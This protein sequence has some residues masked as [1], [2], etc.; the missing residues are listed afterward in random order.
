MELNGNIYWSH[1]NKPLIKHISGVINNAKKLAE[2]TS[3][4][5]WAE[6]TAIYH[7]LGKINPNFQE[8]LKPIPNPQGY[9]NHAYMS[10]YSFFVAFGCVSSNKGL[11]A[12]WLGVEKISKNDLIS[13]T[14]IIAKHHGNLPNY[15]PIDIDGTGSHILSKDENE[16]LHKFLNEKLDLP[17]DE[18][19]K[20]FFSEIE[21]FES[22]L[23]D[24]K[25]QKGYI[26]KFIFNAVS[27]QK[28]L[29]FY[30]DTQY[31]F[32]CLIQGDKTDAAKF[33]VLVDS[34]SLIEENILDVGR[35]CQSYQ[36]QLNFYLSKLNQDSE[37]NRLRTEIRHEA[38]DKIQYGLKEGKRVFELT[39]PTGSGKTLMLL[40]L[41]SEVMKETKKDLRIIYAL[42]FL[43]ITEQVETEVLKIFSKNQNFIQRI[44]SKSQ[45]AEFERLQKKLDEDPDED[46]MRKMNLM[47]FME[48]T[49]AHPFI[50][51]TFVRFF[52]TLLS[53]RNS[54]LLKLPNF[55]N[56]VFL[57]DEI[58]ALPPRLYGFFVAYLTK[59]CEKFDS[60]A[61]I[62]T[63]T[64]PNFDLPTHRLP[65]E[66]NGWFDNSKYAVDFFSD[67]GKP[68]PLLSLDYFKNDLFN[69]YQI[70]FNKD[71]IDNEELKKQIIDENESVLVILNTID[72]TKDLYKALV[73]NGF[74]KNEVF[75]LNT[76]FTPKH[77][78]LKIYLAKRRLKENKKIILIS[79]QL[80]EAGVDI[81]FPILY[82][83]FATIPSIIQSAGRCN[84][85]GKLKKMGKVELFRLGKNGRPR[86]EVIYRGLDEAI[87]KLTKEE[88]REEEYEEKTLL[89]IQKG[90][91][92][93][94]K[95]ELK[96]AE[97]KQSKYNQY[98]H[99]LKDIQ[100]CQFDK[101][102]KFQL[103][104][105]Q[106]Y[107]IP[108]QYF[109]PKN[110]DDS[111]FENLLELKN[112][113]EEMAKTSNDKTALRLRKKKIES[114]LRKMSG[115]IVQVRIRPK[116]DTEPLKSSSEDYLGYLFKLSLSS[117]S[118]TKGVDLKGDDCIL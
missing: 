95:D 79:T 91:F 98:F 38:V 35:F 59:F 9:A 61:V 1:P 115:Q 50:I 42:P 85:N 27:N 112:E 37:L 118:F 8:K 43:S 94:I 12:D 11:I 47:E 51:T 49:F 6:L 90:F 67:Y 72:D 110:D 3:A 5:K 69:R 117:Y 73:D 86:A 77:R 76:H 39:S 96:F 57:L 108:M 107:G 33:D 89:E 21:S 24:N 100:E 82:R 74:S 52:E 113:L 55:K 20:Y 104:D 78:K 62:S 29:D 92:T 109:V 34:N 19:S 116:H 93:R 13:L 58:Q 83:D 106:E 75:L 65:K 60:Y 64:Q 16:A 66:G 40:S 80:I 81:D 14:I 103:I 68:Y 15:C 97:H 2:N 53:N 102:G 114:H 25:I 17:I 48:S 88:F 87:L 7:D 54:E 111:Q 46:T 18:Y 31:A 101:I 70:N 84:R 71:L 41:A 36:T 23:R 105:E 30:L 10:A 45:N 32:A 56:C 4:E 26:E 44:D 28:A 99:F 63:A 22:I